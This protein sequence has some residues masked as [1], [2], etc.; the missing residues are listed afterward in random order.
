[1][2]METRH[3]NPTIGKDGWALISAEEP[4]VLAPDLFL[5]PAR[6]LRDALAVG[7]AAK[8]LFDIETR[9]DGK[10]VDRGTDRMWVLIK[11]RT[12]VGY[13][14]VLDNDPG[15][16][17]NLNLHEGDLVHFGPEHICHI[18]TPPRDYV[19]EKYGSGFF[20]G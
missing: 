11:S 18:D 1:M 19:I 13:I 2:Q 3:S 17:E 8:L 16:A 4:A 15:V 14:G 5:I 6:P 20:G 10:V 12:A 7:T 9:E